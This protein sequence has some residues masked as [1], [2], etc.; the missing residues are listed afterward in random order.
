M[1]LGCGGG[2]GF[3]GSIPGRLPLG[4][5]L[6]ALTGGNDKEHGRRNI[7]ERRSRELKGAT[8]VTHGSK[9]KP[10]LPLKPTNINSKGITRIKA[11]G[12]RRERELQQVERYQQ[13]F[14]R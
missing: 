2:E 11:K 12:L 4:R 8:P 1:E 3:P 7:P 5:R 6:A 14:G 9:T 10:A 13:N